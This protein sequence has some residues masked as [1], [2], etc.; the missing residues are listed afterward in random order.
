MDFDRNSYCLKHL[1]L[2]AD[3]NIWQFRQVEKGVSCITVLSHVR[4]K[5]NKQKHKVF[6]L[7]KNVTR[8]I[9]LKSG[10]YI[11]QNIKTSSID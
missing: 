3:L 9:S 5:Q 1:I 4:V 8:G 10:T 7:H 6:A 2:I 11:K